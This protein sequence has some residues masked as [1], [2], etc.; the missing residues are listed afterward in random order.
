MF[1]SSDSKISGST[2]EQNMKKTKGFLAQLEY[3][4][5]FGVQIWKAAND[6]FTVHVKG[7]V[8]LSTQTV[9]ST[10]LREA[11]STVYDLVWKEQH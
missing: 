4:S 7:N 10:D 5:G 1:I 6:E 11:V 3:L 9:Q 2:G 8:T